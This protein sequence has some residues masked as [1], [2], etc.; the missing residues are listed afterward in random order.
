MAAVGFSGQGLTLVNKVQT[1]ANS[2]L[3]E[4]V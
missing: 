2:S 4:R 1:D 3:V